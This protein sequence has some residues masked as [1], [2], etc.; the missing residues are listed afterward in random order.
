LKKSY[1]ASKQLGV[2]VKLCLIYLR[3]G[4]SELGMMS[5]PGWLHSRTQVRKRMD[6]PGKAFLCLLFWNKNNFKK[7]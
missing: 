6:T 2:S 3:R 4:V 1:T 7:W 5:H